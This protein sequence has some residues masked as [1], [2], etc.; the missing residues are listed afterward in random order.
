MFLQNDL[1]HTK[2]N[3]DSKLEIVGPKDIEREIEAYL[4]KVR[5]L[6]LNDCYI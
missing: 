5:Q 2:R 4:A 1:K 3:M 6:A